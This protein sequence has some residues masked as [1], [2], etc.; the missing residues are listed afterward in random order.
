M[1]EQRLLTSEGYAKLHEEYQYY[2][3]T[4]RPQ[5]VHR[6]AEA[7]AEGDRSENAEYIYGKKKLRDIDNRIRYLSKILDDARVINPAELDSDVVCF[8]A[9]VHIEDEDGVA[10]VWTLVG[11]GES[12]SDLGRITYTSPV[13]RALIGKR[14]GDVVVVKLPAGERE[15]EL[16]DLR[17]G[18]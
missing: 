9:T 4:L 7:A 18:G 1:A 16:T 6:I 10:H 3:K 5:T 14:V 11:E 12:D 8:G 2:W 13:G 15:Y 17:F